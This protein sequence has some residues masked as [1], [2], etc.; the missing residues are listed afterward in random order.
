MPADEAEGELDE[1]PLGVCGI[2]PSCPE[3]ST[4]STDSGLSVLTGTTV[5]HHS[6]PEKRS[7]NW[8]SLAAL[9][10]SMSLVAC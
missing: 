5:E 8:E 2:W 10:A 6:T 9:E 3:Y 1:A 4:V 7:S